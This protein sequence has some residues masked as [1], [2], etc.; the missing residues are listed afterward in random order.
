MI[1]KI[2]LQRKTSNNEETTQNEICLTIAPEFV[3]EQAPG[4]SM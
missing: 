2:A 3:Q 1:V 4:L